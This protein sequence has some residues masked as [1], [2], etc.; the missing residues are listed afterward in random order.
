VGGTNA[1][2]AWQDH[3]GAP[4]STVDT[5]P[6]S[7]HATLAGAMRHYLE[8][9]HKAA[10]AECA[11]GIATA[12]AGDRVAML[13][14][15]W[16]FSISELQAALGVRRLVVLNDFQALALSLPVLASGELHAVGGGTPV[17][18]AT[19][20]VMG[21]GTGLGAALLVPAVPGRAAITV[22]GEG[23][24]VTLAPTDDYE[25]QVVRRLHARF[26]HASGERALSGQGL[27]NLHGAVCEVEGIPVPGLSAAQ[28][29]QR[30]VDSATAGPA[31]PHCKRTLALFFSL[32]GTVA[33]NYALSVG[34]RGGF[35]LGGGI[36][37]RLGS[38]IDESAFRE[39]F[40]AKGR[41]RP[42]MEAI[43]VYVIRAQVS[44][45][46]LGSAVALD[47]A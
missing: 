17:P 28:V 23:G 20:A 3:A 6:C 47:M 24:H 44:P 45:A 10:P 5:L 2:F 25:E 46:L 30:A 16:V 8:R 41:L 14:H 12:V 26:G 22:D 9:H 4:L 36:L 38:L 13:N 1:R 31:D 37:P 35:Y 40:N 42:Y 32:L 18:G 11:F 21:P 15:P 7:A 27:E 19:K 29:T 39:K 34:A 43:P 33:G